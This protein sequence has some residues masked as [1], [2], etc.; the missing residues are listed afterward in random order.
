MNALLYKNKN[1]HNKTKRVNNVMTFVQQLLRRLKL[2]TKN[3]GKRLI[4]AN[5]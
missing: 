5:I 4:H 2:I 1:K 3:N